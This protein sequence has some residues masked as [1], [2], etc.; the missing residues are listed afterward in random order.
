M[1]LRISQQ[2]PSTDGLAADLRPHLA[3]CFARDP[4]ARPTAQQVSERLQRDQPTAAHLRPTLMLTDSAHTLVE[5]PSPPARSTPPRRPEPSTSADSGIRP[6]ERAPLAPAGHVRRRWLLA[7]AAAV[8]VL[9][10]ST[11]VIVANQ[12][13][14][15]PAT[16][17]PAATPTTPAP[18]PPARKITFAGQQLLSGHRQ[19]IKYGMF[20]PDGRTLATGSQEDDT[21]VRLWDTANGQQI[22]STFESEYAAAFSPDGTILATGGDNGRVTLRDARNRREIGLLDLGM[23]EGA[24]VVAIAFSPDGRTVAI[25]TSRNSVV[26][27][28]NVASRTLL[29]T[30]PDNAAHYGTERVQFTPDGRF[31][32]VSGEAGKPEFWDVTTG[33]SAWT[34]AENGPATLSAD[35]RRLAVWEQLQNQNIVVYDTSTRQSLIEVQQ[36]GGPAIISPDGTV[37]AGEGWKFWDVATGRLIADFNRRGTPLAFSPDMK[38]VA[39]AFGLQIVLANVSVNAA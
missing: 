27:L 3:A 33:Q 13:T 12:P 5:D 29:S 4:A 14:S 28:W 34:P 30:W 17:P 2:E 38:T 35:G 18:P 23:Q 11:T 22:G 16:P 20:S 31:L 9:G 1:L 15:A 8:T 21:S 10:I 37:I 39:Y 32:I 26:S 19:P 6:T 36:G 7:G 25:R 24:W